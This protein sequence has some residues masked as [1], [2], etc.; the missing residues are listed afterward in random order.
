MTTS[1]APRLDL[2]LEVAAP[3]VAGPLAVFPLFG[4]P[5][6]MLYKPFAR[7]VADGVT[8]R[9]RPG[10]AS[11]NDLVVDNPTPDA[12]LLY[13]GEEVAGAQQDR[14]FDVSV[15]VAP[16][17]T[18]EVPVS[19]VEHGRWD[20]SRHH[21]AFS[22]APH[23]AFPELRRVKAMRAR[24]HAA[25]GLR[26][27]ADQGEVWA[28]V[29]RKHDRLA[30]ASATGA[31]RDIFDGRREHLDELRAAIRPRPGQVGTLC[32]I[33]GRFV[34]LD[35]A[36]RPDAFAVLAE[37]LVRGYALDALEHLG[38][39]RLPDAP[40]VD[41]AQAFVAAACAAPTA[42]R[43]GVGLGVE[44]RFASDGVSGTALVHD[45]EVVQLTAFGEERPRPS[46]RIRRA[47][48]RR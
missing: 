22:P 2:D 11:V 4:P 33:A 17:T 34:V 30:T 3:D 46:V 10:H 15:L 27:R 37:P 38:A 18:L 35:H 36:S 41:A 14:T 24:Q 44:A 28:T 5:P 9:E 16:R 48:R 40:S 43:P 7:A 31:M 23:A 29:E 39:V 42:E 6:R 19:C 12:V 1:T 13:D 20:G 26:A 47:S 21:E 32:A 8:V 45:G 25:A